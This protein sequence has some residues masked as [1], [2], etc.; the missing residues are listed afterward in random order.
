[1]ARRRKLGNVPV[2]AGR[3]RGKLLLD[4]GPVKRRRRRKTGDRR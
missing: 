2:A 1:M 4:G 3:G